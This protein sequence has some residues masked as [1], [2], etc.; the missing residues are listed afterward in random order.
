MSCDIP[1]HAV[2]IR[3]KLWH[4]M[5]CRD[6][7]WHP[8]MSCD[9]LWHFLFFC[10][11]QI[12]NKFNTKCYNFHVYIMLTACL[13]YHHWIMCVCIIKWLSSQLMCCQVA[14]QPAHVLSSGCPAS[15]FVIKWLSSQL[16]CYQVAVQPAYVSNGCPATP[17]NNWYI[18][19]WLVYPS[20]GCPATHANQLATTASV[21]NTHTHKDLTFF[22]SKC[23]KTVCSWYIQ[24][25]LLKKWKANCLSL[26]WMIRL[27]NNKKV[28]TILIQCLHIIF[29]FWHV[30]VVK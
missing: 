2:T 18:I 29:Y 23:L 16:I 7:L 8:M 30:D 12:R 1:W 13:S 25:P 14:V 24:C 26:S 11:F 4:P 20:V 22:N 5:T 28:I 6:I 15:S 9:I 21:N 17:H 19:N 27:P 3:D 10:I